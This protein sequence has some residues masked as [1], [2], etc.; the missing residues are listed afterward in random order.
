M[1]VAP[2]KKR[3]APGTA[4]IELSADGVAVATVSHRGESHRLTRCRFYPAATE[5][6]RERVL[7]QAARECGLDQIR[8]V[9]VIDEEQFNLLLVEAPEV[10]P[11]ELRA[12]VRWR[13]KDLIDFHVDDAVVDV[14]DIPAQRGVRARM[15]YVV[16]A[17]TAT[18]RRHIDRLEAAKVRLDVIDIPELVLR[19]VAAI[20]P[21]DQSG[22]GL[23]QL[24]RT[25]GTLALTRQGDLYLS[26]AL[27]LG[28]DQLLA[29]RPGEADATG[30]GFELEAA[31][32]DGSQ[33]LFDSIVLEVQRSLDYYESHFALPPV[34]AL[35]IA[36]LERPVPHLVGHLA[37][38]LGIPVRLMDVAALLETDVPLDD[39]VQARCLRAIGAALRQEEKRL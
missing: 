37:R 28:L 27:D 15:M 21:E 38:N 34:S 9:S 7:E 26:R 23:L 32:L 8:C 14:F 16:A 6:E 20:L 11:T 36:P 10:D 12:A 5:P 13:I 31:P 35:V 25:S 19:N 39:A 22:V 30:D 1:F 24:G 3:H 18:V 4:G 29:E 33:R 2:W 17:R